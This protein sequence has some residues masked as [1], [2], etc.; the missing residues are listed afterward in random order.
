LREKA[1]H[2]SQKK[3]KASSLEFVDRLGLLSIRSAKRAAEKQLNK[4]SSGMTSIKIGRDA[5]PP[6]KRSYAF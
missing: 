2:E 1:T 3:H 6:G 4:R 5:N